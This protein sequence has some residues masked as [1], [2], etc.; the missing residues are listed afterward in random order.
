[1]NDGATYPLKRGD[2]REP[3]TPSKY[4]RSAALPGRGVRSGGVQGE[5]GRK[6]HGIPDSE[7]PLRLCQRLPESERRVHR[8]RRGGGKRLRAIAAQG[9]FR[10]G[11]RRDAEVD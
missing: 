5:L 6:H 11:D 1:M 8:C 2:V 4:R 10:S 7:N 3:D 9:A